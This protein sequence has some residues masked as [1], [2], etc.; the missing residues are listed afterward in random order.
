MSNGD[1]SGKNTGN[2]GNGDIDN[3]AGRGNGL[4]CWY[5]ENR[6]CKFRKKLLHQKLYRQFFLLE[7]FIF[8]YLY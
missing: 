8:L 2:I 6:T 3:S 4:L 1:N 5:H 7:Y